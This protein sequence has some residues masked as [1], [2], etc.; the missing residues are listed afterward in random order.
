MDADKILF[1]AEHDGSASGSRQTAVLADG[2]VEHDARA[3]NEGSVRRIKYKTWTRKVVSEGSI[4]PQPTPGRLVLIGTGHVFQIRDTI[5]E[6]IE[7]LGPDVVFVELDRGR[8]NALMHREKTGQMPAG[9]GGFV[10][11]RMQRF[12]QD[13]AKL[14][15]AEVGGEMVAAVQAGQAAGAQVRLIDRLGQTTIRRAVKELTWRERGRAVGQLIK[16]GFARIFPSKG[17]GLEAELQKYQDDPNAALDELKR[18][19]PT[20]WRVVIDERDEH[21]AKAIRHGLMG[22]T[23]GVAVV[24][25]GHVGGIMERLSDVEITAYR[26]PDVRAGNLPKPAPQVPGPS[27]MSFGFDL[28]W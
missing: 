16:A 1:V 10:Q 19:F 5:R 22:A 21:M 9:K 12:Q 23:L 2:A 26:L 20:I 14:Y 6:A 28:Q 24:G 15:N 8:L 18:Q 11:T 25:D 3:H 13:V 27:D 7:A 17:P 4:T